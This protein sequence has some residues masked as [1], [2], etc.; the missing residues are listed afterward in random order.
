MRS[1]R[2]YLYLNLGN[3][4]GGVIQDDIAGPWAT[5]AYLLLLYVFCVILWQTSK[6]TQGGVFFC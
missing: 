6:R 5:A 4:G 3:G 1:L 2:T